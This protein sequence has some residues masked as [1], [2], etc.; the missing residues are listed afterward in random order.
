MYVTRPL[1]IY[2]KSTEAALAPP[3]EGLNSGY[4]VFADEEYETET[5]RFFGLCKDNKIRNLPFPQNKILTVR[6]TQHH[7]RIQNHHHH[8]LSSSTVYSDKAYFIPVLDQPLSSNRYYIIHESGNYKGN[9]CRCSREEDMVTCCFCKC[10]NDVK[11]RALDHRDMYQQVE[12]IRQRGGCFV[13]KSIA[14]DG[15]PPLFLRRKGWEV[16][17]KTPHDFQL[18]EAH[19][20]DLSLR[21]HLPAF[22]FP[23]SNK[24]SRSVVVGKWYIPFM[25]I[26]EDGTSS[27]DQMKK[28]MFYEMYLEQMWDEIHM[29]E[30]H[31]TEQ[32]AVVVKTTVR[33]ETATILGMEAVAC[34]VDRVMWLSGPPNSMGV[35]LSMAIVDRMKWEACRGGWIDGKER[36]LKVERVEEFGGVNGWKKF[37]CYMLVER[38]VLRRM[39]ESL[40]L[41]YDFNHTHLIQS[42]WE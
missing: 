40:V 9:A 6:Y 27:K 24:H 19:G 16:Y 39:D 22:D 11:P 8:H 23:I 41:T 18:G 7:M 15:F 36:D 4:L 10:I 2:T 32:N 5:T 20:I 28:S 13:A 35:G 34:V 42:K 17:T 30:N 14:P 3:P 12:I 29:C 21:A 26:K 38:F 37:G 1:S 33:R 25:F 31:G